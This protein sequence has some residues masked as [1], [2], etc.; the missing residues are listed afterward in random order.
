MCVHSL[1]MDGNRMGTL[2]HA[3]TAPAPSAC[4]RR[5]LP[6]WCVPALGVPAPQARTHSSRAAGGGCTLVALRLH[7]GA[8]TGTVR[9]DDLGPT[10]ICR[11]SSSLLALAQGRPRAHARCMQPPSP[12]SA[13]SRASRS[14]NE[15]S[16]KDERGGGLH[17]TWHPPHSTIT[18]QVSCISSPYQFHGGAQC[19]GR[20]R[21]PRELSAAC[22]A[23]PFLNH[24][25][26]RE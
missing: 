25:A 21:M 26:H 23:C 11:K 15:A 5:V 7:L 24:S 4:A 10:R 16:F 1:Q 8:D 20:Q 14:A 19:P 17:A 18:H 13:G 12:W 3:L 2:E 9:R 6:A 22:P